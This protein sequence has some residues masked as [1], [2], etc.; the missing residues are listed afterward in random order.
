MSSAGSYRPEAWA[1]VDQRGVP[2][3]PG[4]PHNNNNN[5]NNSS[6]RNSTNSNGCNENNSNNG[7]RVAEYTGSE[8][9]YDL[10]TAGY[11][12]ECGRPC[13]IPLTPRTRWSPPQTGAL[14]DQGQ[15]ATPD[16]A[17]I[18]ERL[19][20]DLDRERAA[21][22]RAEGRTAVTATAS[23]FTTTPATTT[24]A[25]HTLQVGPAGQPTAV[26]TQ[27]T[28]Q[29]PPQTQYLLSPPPPPP[30]FAPAPAVMTATPGA[31]ATAPT[32]APV[33]AVAATPGTNGV[34]AAAATTTSSRAPP[35]TTSNRT[36]LLA[37]IP[38]VVVALLFAAWVVW[39]FSGIERRLTAMAA[40]AASTAPPPLV[41]PV[42]SPVVTAP[43][44]AT[45]AAV[46]QR[47]GMLAVDTNNQYYYAR[48]IAS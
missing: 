9:Y 32:G 5:N 43:T 17:I 47:G 25:A 48:P 44:P 34:G 4:G 36:L 40:H 39:R 8:I 45:A 20:D 42:V 12:D 37:L 15:P 41:S 24:T 14:H 46:P 19:L 28:A 1:Y 16:M 7:S 38:I 26:L 3:D 22:A 21:R 10:H 31:V 13:A 6:S 35:G 29:Q 11:A 23:S 2:V 33:G 30:G 18:I 27:Q